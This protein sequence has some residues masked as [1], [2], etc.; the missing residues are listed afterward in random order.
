MP[1]AQAGGAHDSLFVGDGLDNNVKVFDAA[2]G[3]F[4]RS[5]PTATAPVVGPRGIVLRSDNLFLVNQ[6]VNTPFN[7]EILRFGAV[8]GRLRSAVVAGKPA[9]A[10]FAPRGLILW[11]NHLFVANVCNPCVPPDT[12][13]G[14]VFRYTAAGT[15]RV[16]LEPPPGPS[17]FH[18]FGVVIGPDGLLYVS[19]RPNLFSTGLGGQ[20]LQYHPE[21]GKF[22]K[23]FIS[24]NGGDDGSTGPKAW[25]SGRMADCTSPAFA[26]ASGIPTK[27]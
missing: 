20:V 18:P 2:T 1:A 21:T 22:L 9:D 27:S 6:N 19:A 10:P 17:E 24:S 26:P 15:D 8:T 7:G 23:T 13:G 16:T 12:G 3:A 11:R 14:G 4:Q 25:C 5:L